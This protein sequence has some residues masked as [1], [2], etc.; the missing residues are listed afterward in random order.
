[1]KLFLKINF[2]SR[3][4]SLTVAWYTLYCI[5]TSCSIESIV[6]GKFSKLN[7]LISEE[8]KIESSKQSSRNVENNLSEYESSAI[9]NY[10]Y[11]YSYIIVTVKKYCESSQKIKAVVSTQRYSILLRKLWHCIL[12]IILYWRKLPLTTIISIIS[13][14][15]DL[16]GNYI[17]IRFI[18]NCN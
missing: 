3:R 18:E 15:C 7:N 9:I 17:A 4:N 1:M 12:G 8:K 16:L 11:M 5:F 10:H 2:S 13:C 6:T 14:N